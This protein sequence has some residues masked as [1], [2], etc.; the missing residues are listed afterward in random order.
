[1]L[2]EGVLRVHRSDRLGTSFSRVGSLEDDVELLKGSAFRLH[3]EEVYEYEFE[4][5]PKYEEDVE[6]VSNLYR[7]ISTNS[8][9][10]KI[11]K[12]LTLRKATGA[13]KVFTNPAHPDVSWNTPMPFARMSFDK[14]SP[15]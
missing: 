1:V 2:F 11:S 15:G 6:P 9:I 13:A 4:Q 8:D 3:V 10:W 7:S 12:I 14:T 5:V